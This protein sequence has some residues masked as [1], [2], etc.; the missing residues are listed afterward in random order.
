M[1]KPLLTDYLPE[2]MEALKTQLEDDFKRWGDVWK[3]R[4][5]SGQEERIFARYA[6]YYN[7]YQFRGVPIPWLKIVGEALIAWV[8]EQHN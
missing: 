7:D 6:E 3:Y 4:T 2:F 8:R 5:R 1:Y